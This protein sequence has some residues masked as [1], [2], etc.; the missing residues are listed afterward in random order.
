MAGQVQAMSLQ[1]GTIGTA[2]AINSCNCRQHE[3]PPRELP[4][5]DEAD[6][7]KHDETESNK[8]GEGRE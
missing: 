5:E 7:C 4:P 8:L 6:D 3:N 1:V 2:T